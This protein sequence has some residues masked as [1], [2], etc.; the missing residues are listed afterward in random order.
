MARTKRFYIKQRHRF[1]GLAIPVV[2]VMVAILGFVAFSFLT[3][4]SAPLGSQTAILNGDT[5][6]HGLCEAALDKAELSLRLEP[7]VWVL[8]QTKYSNLIM[9]GKKVE[10][11]IE[12]IEWAH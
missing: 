9:D 8:G 11:K 4:I 3:A 10:V 7:H 6:Y 12:D 2:M 1:R 5:K